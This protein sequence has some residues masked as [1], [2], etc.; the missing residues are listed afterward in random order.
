MKIIKF[1]DKLEDRVRGR[2][3][4]YPI[5]YAV[6]GG[7]GVVVFWRGVW[8]ASDF[9]SASFLAW[10]S[11]SPTI[12]LTQGLDGLISF[13]AG[14]ILLL[15]T[16][17]FI[18]SFIGNEIIISGLKGEKKLTEKTESELKSE[19]ATIEEAEI[20]IEKVIKH[21]DELEHRLLSSLEKIDSK[22]D[23]NSRVDQS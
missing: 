18:S 16:G 15:S 1:F 21:I 4:H 11:N 8:H 9:I 22:I 12:D 2:L 23:R 17:L 13:F 14:L 5:L 7:I 6:L 10:K 3:S 20:K 19:T